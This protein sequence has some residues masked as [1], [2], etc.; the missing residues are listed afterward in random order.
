MPAVIATPFVH[1]LS[2]R[3]SEWRSKKLSAAYLLAYDRAHDSLITY[4]A[5]LNEEDWYRSTGFPLPIRCPVSVRAIFMTFA[6]MHTRAHLAEINQSLG[7]ATGREDYHAIMQTLVN[8][9][10]TQREEIL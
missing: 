7:V 9:L 10:R 1:E 6:P 8:T 3:F 4:T 2:Y 5:T